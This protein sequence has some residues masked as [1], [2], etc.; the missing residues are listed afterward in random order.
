MEKYL[1]KMLVLLTLVVILLNLILPPSYALYHEIGMGQSFNVAVEAKNSNGIFNFDIKKSPIY[2]PND[3]TSLTSHQQKSLLTNGD[4]PY[5]KGAEE[6]RHPFFN[7]LSAI[8]LGFIAGFL[9]IVNVWNFAIFGVL[10]ATYISDYN[11]ILAQKYQIGLD[12]ATNLSE[13]EKKQHKMVYYFFTLDKLFFGD[14]RMLDVN[15]FKILNKDGSGIGLD[16][17]YDNIN[18]AFKAGIAKWSGVTRLMALSITFL[19]FIMAIINLLLKIGA[20]KISGVKTEKVKQLIQDLAVTIVIIFFLPLLMAL[21]LYLVDFLMAVLNNFR[22]TLLEG[23]VRNFEADIFVKIFTKVSLTTDYTISI[24][25]IMYLIFLQ[26]KYFAVFLKRFLSIAIMTLIAPI[27]AVTYSL[28][29][30]GDNK[31]QIFNGFISE[32]IQT[33]MLAPMYALMYII[34]MLLLGGIATTQPFLGVIILTFF[35]KIEKQMKALFGIGAMTLV[36]DSKTV[37]GL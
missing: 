11:P 1:L 5:E 26:V 31:S 22:Y 17:K 16:G 25:T 14:I 18:A 27:V 35:Q 7:G 12:L 13:L 6:V 21:I 30:A 19:I 10:T 3:D 15:M 4:A 23:G 9:A 8:V 24:I 29:R 2:D 34:F 36:T 32:Y 37:I 20:N 33:A 28:D